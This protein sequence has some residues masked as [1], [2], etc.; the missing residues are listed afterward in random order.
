[1]H[2][3]HADPLGPRYA[4][5][6]EALFQLS[7][8]Y[9]Q[10]VT[11]SAGCKAEPCT[12]ATATISFTP[13]PSPPASPERKEPDSL[14]F[15]GLSPCHEES[16][17]CSEVVKSMAKV[18]GAISKHL[19][20]C[21]DEV[22]DELD[23]WRLVESYARDRVAQ[24]ATPLTRQCSSPH[25]LTAEDTTLIFQDTVASPLSAMPSNAALK[26]FLTPV[27]KGLLC[28]YTLGDR[29]GEGGFGTVYKAM[30]PGG[31]VF[32]VK[33][34]PVRSDT[35]TMLARQEYSILKMLGHRNIVKVW[36]CKIN[37]CS[38][39]IVMTYWTQGSINH[40]IKEFGALSELTIKRYLIQLLNGLNYL[41]KC[42]VIHG[43][44]KPQNML[45]DSTGAVA[46][47]D[48]GL[49]ST[50]EIAEA[51]DGLK[52][53]TVKGTV[54]YLSRSVCMGRSSSEQADIWAMGCSVLEMARLLT[55]WKH[56]YE[57]ISQLIFSV[58]RD[59]T[60]NPL[61]SVPM[62]LRV[63]YSE[64]FFD[65][66]GLCFS[67]ETSEIV[68]ELSE[69]S[70]AVPPP[71]YGSNED[72]SCDVLVNHV[73]FGASNPHITQKPKIVRQLQS[74]S[75]ALFPS[76]EN[77][78]THPHNVHAV[79]SW[80]QIIA[81]DSPANLASPYDFDI[82]VK[83][84]GATDSETYSSAGEY[85]AYPHR[86]RPAYTLLSKLGRSNEPTFTEELVRL[87][88]NVVLTPP[89][90]LARD[91]ETIIIN[92][93]E[94]QR[95]AD[96][97]AH[98]DAGS[99]WVNVPYPTDV[100]AEKVYGEKEFKIS[101]R[102]VKWL[103][104]STHVETTE[105]FDRKFLE[106]LTALVRGHSQGLNEA[107]FQ[108][109]YLKNCAFWALY[110]SVPLTQ[111]GTETVPDLGEVM[112]QRKKFDDES[113]PYY[114]ESRLQWEAASRKAFTDMAED[115]NEEVLSWR[116]DVQSSTFEYGFP[117][118]A[119]A[120]A[121]LEQSP[122]ELCGSL[123]LS[124]QGYF[125][126]EGCYNEAAQS[127]SYC[128]LTEKTPVPVTFL[129]ATGI[130]FSDDQVRMSEMPRYFKRISEDNE[131]PI[132]S[133]FLALGEYKLLQRMKGKYRS[134]F[135]SA[136]HHRA[137]H[138]SML[139]MGLGVFLRGIDSGDRERI[140]EVYLKSQF[141]LLCEEEWGFH[142]YYLSVGPPGSPLRDLAERV[143]E[144][145]QRTSGAL[146]CNVLLHCCDA[147]FLAVEIA[148]KGLRSAILN[149]SDINT[150]L[151][152]LAG[153]SW[154]RGRYS[155]YSGEQDMCAHSTAVLAHANI[156]NS[157]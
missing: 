81:D 58:T 46:L 135:L 96:S 41:H 66:V 62:E 138:P 71:P 25:W 19:L 27:E 119:S 121:A 11:H 136:K 74:G 127:Y 4:S 20:V 130:D 14:P 112:R 38:A 104:Q 105:D 128:Q 65:F 45:V 137:R 97:D 141:E 124:Q 154:E 73:F 132:F 64:S 101:V 7:L 111:L 142:T 33:V 150:L 16:D 103:V 153:G 52:G 3:T 55:P 90:S 36:E 129:S 102:E 107:K 80:H 143:L 100:N 78:V 84:A 32:A 24:C 152:G 8:L 72:L 67:P 68:L 148:K 106:A 88:P 57:H 116:R 133:G 120:K 89:L 29:L 151:L 30:D 140:W 40:Q 23:A 85:Q 49:C 44:I 87:V 61:K 50:K 145:V 82:C 144:G 75:V 53:M 139:P 117:S 43:D 31:T 21:G 93:K 98:F 122:A 69:Q 28:G 123:C 37:R 118:S 60:L 17:E 156:V 42:G 92:A 149:P 83:K 2:L 147:K 155:Y 54:H 76:R 18:V 91:D 109:Q 146:R 126:V 35:D 113:K 63:Q 95:I 1:M 47:T 79:G 110:R 59:A 26:S 51:A 77:E 5:D 56:T 13:P 157:I 115:V 6:E 125:L 10:N 34:M 94:I 15:T 99:E 86:F 114:V 12:F 108:E 134:I 9:L 70:G 39:E 22:G 48:F 131:D